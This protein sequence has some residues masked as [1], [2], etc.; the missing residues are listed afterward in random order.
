MRKDRHRPRP[1]RPAARR[2]SRHGRLRHVRRRRPGGN[3]R[4]RVRPDPREHDRADLAGTHERPRPVV[5]GRQPADRG[6]PAPPRHVPRPGT[7]PGGRAAGAGEPA[8]TAGSAVQVPARAVRRD[9]A[10]GI[11]RPRAGGKPAAADR[12]RA[13]HRARCHRAGRDPR[14]AA[15]PR[16]APGDGDHPGHPRLGSARRPL[17]PCPRHV[18]GGGRGTSQ[19]RGPLPVAAAPLH[20]RA[21][22]RQPA[23]GAGRG[24]T[25]GHPRH[26]AAA[27]GLARRVPLPAPVPRTRRANAAP[28]SSPWRNPHPAG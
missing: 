5:P 23:P 24:H 2:R 3:A 21:A 11:D 17:R 19:R 16:Q 13:H 27:V 20:R 10:A 12:R 9:G 18:R 22:G 14:P 8:G 1:A 26:G 15:G 25:A 28:A 6:D 4:A 7:S